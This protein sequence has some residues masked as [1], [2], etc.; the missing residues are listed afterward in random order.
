MLRRGKS[1]SR[2]ESRSRGFCKVALAI[3]KQRQKKK[4]RP[5]KKAQ[6]CLLLG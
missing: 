4:A 3:K 6:L 1:L 2:W 5:R